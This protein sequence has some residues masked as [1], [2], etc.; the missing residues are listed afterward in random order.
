MTTLALPAA[1]VGIGCSAVIYGTDIFCALV[2]RPAAAEASAA[3]IADLIGRV[4]KYGDRR[5]PLPG[6]TSLLA[7]AIAAAFANPT[8]R[9]GALAA[10]AA[11]I[12]WLAIYARVSAPINK[13]L[14]AA[15]AARSVPDTTREM[16]QRWDS[17]IWPRAALQAIALAGLLFTVI[18]R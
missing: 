11:L 10:L 18:A 7:A 13:Q 9:V 17:V 5:L 12:G 3:S 4:H 14:R 2:L 15:S 16:Q 1:V 6:V 8:A